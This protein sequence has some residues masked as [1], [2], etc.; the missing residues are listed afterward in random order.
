MPK[1]KIILHVQNPNTYNCMETKWE[2]KT[3]MKNSTK[4]ASENKDTPVRKWS[5]ALKDL[6]KN[7]AKEVTAMANKHMKR[8]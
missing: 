8:R 6:N 3:L 5:R 7:L 1:R 4:S 2:G